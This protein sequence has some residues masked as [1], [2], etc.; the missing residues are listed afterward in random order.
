MEKHSKKSFK[1][2]SNIL[3]YLNSFINVII[4]LLLI[5][6]TNSAFAQSKKEIINSL[7]NK[8]DSLMEVMMRKDS[9]IYQYQQSITSLSSS[10]KACEIKL[11]DNLA[12]IEERNKAILRLKNDSIEQ[13]FKFK[14]LNENYLNKDSVINYIRSRNIVLD[15]LLNYGVVERSL[16]TQN[17]T[18]CIEE[19]QESFYL[20]KCIWRNFMSTRRCEV[21]DYRGHCDNTYQLFEL[22]GNC[23]LEISNSQLFNDKVNSLLALLNSEVSKEYNLYYMDP[24][25]KDCFNGPFRPYKLSDFNLQFEETGIV[26]SVDFD[27]PSLCRAVGGSIVELSWKDLEKYLR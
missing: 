12:M 16:S 10:Q 25:S 15:S 17:V 26:F 7:Q 9:L 1:Y 20:K 27:V 22:N 24:E 14:I 21:Y 13:L 8:V 4:F 11:R 18:L 19:E 3:K 5:I 23:Y 6:N 2:S